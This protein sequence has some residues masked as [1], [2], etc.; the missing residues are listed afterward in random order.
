V[1]YAEMASKA[2]PLYICSVMIGRSI[3]LRDC[4]MITSPADQMYV[5]ELGVMW[6]HAGPDSDQEPS[7]K[8]S[9]GPSYD[10]CSVSDGVGQVGGQLVALFSGRRLY[11]VDCV[12][13][14][15]VCLL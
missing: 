9:N 1:L 13:R 5:G 4:L 8:M 6:F 7:V 10:S 11:V 12:I 2:V 15:M 14:L 3:Q